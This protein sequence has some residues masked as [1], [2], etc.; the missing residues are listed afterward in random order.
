MPT[1]SLICRA[2]YLLRA[3][4]PEYLRRRA[5][6]LDLLHAELD[7]RCY[8]SFS[9][10]KDSAVIAHACHAVR[11]DIPMLMVDPGVPI[12]WTAEERDEWC[13]YAYREGWNLRL[14]PWDKYATERPQEAAEYRASVHADMFCDLTAYAEQH[15]L[16][17]RVMGLRAEES[18]GRR[19]SLGRDRGVSESRICPISLWSGADVWTYI[20]SEGLPW[21]SIYDHLG[22]DARNGLIGRN[23]M[24]RG[25]L[26]YLRRHY[27]EAYRLARE[28][29]ANAPETRQ[30]PPPRA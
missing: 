14:F 2:E 28:L 11:P 10:G 27:P 18:P 1:A 20:V 16:T 6:L 21:L 17:R 5:R 30:E 15:G 7:A 24:E 3:R 8:V 19:M 12:H 4:R 22:P 26:V 13:G 9:A 29:F 23:A 25:R